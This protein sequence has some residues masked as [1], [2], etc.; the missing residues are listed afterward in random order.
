MP[1]LSDFLDR[2][3]PAGAPGAATRTG[4]PADRAAEL[5][6]ELNPVLA[7]LATTAAECDRIVAAADR[8]SKRIINE[9]SERAATIAAEA[10]ARAQVERAEAA[11][12]VLV[13]A[14]EQAAGIGP[15]Q[16]GPGPTDAQV[17]ELVRAAVELVRAIPEAGLS[18][19]R[20]DSDGL[21][22]G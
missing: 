5:S 13:T 22:A 19:S 1:R 3:R 2:F 9:A 16:A 8:N 12:R 14:R 10:R 6:A 20:R 18:G 4:V 11:A 21:D 15:G 17:S 7:Q